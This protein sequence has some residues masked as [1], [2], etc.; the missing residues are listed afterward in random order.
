MKIKKYE[1]AVN[2]Y[3]NTVA[4]ARSA[5]AQR[6]SQI[7]QPPLLSSLLSRL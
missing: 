7:W 4:D 3:A 2:L 6:A 5:L 1:Q